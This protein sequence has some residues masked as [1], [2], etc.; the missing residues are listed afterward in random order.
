MSKIIVLGES[1]KLM[2]NQKLFG[3]KIYILPNFVPSNLFITPESI[4]SKFN[5][6]TKIKFLYLS[7]LMKGKGYDVLIEAFEKMDCLLSS[8]IELHFA[9][10]FDEEE[11]QLFFENKIKKFNNVFYHGVVQSK[12]KKKLLES[13]CVL[14]L[15]SSFLEGQPLCILEAYANACFVITTTPPGIKDIFV[16]EHN[17][18][19]INVNDSED[20]KTKM[21]F[22]I[23]NRSL[24]KEYGLTN[25]QEA[26]D[27]Y[28]YDIFIQNL[29]NL[30]K[31]RN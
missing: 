25:Y 18:L 30:I 24:I 14:V 4:E 16:N 22:L 2:F 19:E 17:G 28:T 12:E 23:H 5:V 1:H 29:N 31:I 3:N 11:S 27:K 9:G 20:L 8:K 6:E 26:K 10:S 13:S 7:N 21:E 15:P